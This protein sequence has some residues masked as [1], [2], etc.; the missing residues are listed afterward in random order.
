MPIITLTTDFGLKDH[1]VGVLK[2]T[3][4]SELKDAVIVDISHL[5]SPFHIQECAYVLKNA[6]HTF[7]PGSIHV[8]GVDAERTPETRHVA[9]KA[10]GHYFIAADNGVLSLIAETAPPEKIFD[11]DL[12]NHLQGPFPT[13]D[14]FVKVACH[15][16]RGG[17][18]EVIGKPFKAL[19]TIKEFAPR[20]TNDGNTLVGSVIYIDNYGNVVTNIHKSL[21]EAYRKGRKFT[22]EARNKKLT[23]IHSQYSGLINY[24]LD[25][26]QRRGPGDLL[27]LVNASGYVELAIYKSNPKTVGGAS[28]LLGLTYRDTV[29]INFE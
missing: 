5:I 16:A 11:I 2:G 8:V 26:S 17:T 19:R 3:I 14:V 18:L 6:Y 10:D 12:P 23:E 24:D 15:L 21:F 27:A 25:P 7:P 28:T 22:L 9:V 20:V 29:I 13:L 1:A 4:Y